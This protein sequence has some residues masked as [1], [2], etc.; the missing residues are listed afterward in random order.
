MTVDDVLCCSG[1]ASDKRSA[2]KH[3]VIV[4]MQSLGWIA[5]ELNAVKLYLAIEFDI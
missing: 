2:K 4:T 5:G 3:T 1:I